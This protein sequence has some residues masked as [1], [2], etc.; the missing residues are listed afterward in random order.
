MSYELK[1]KRAKERLARHEALAQERLVRQAYSAVPELDAN[2][3]HQVL[4][5]HSRR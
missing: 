3:G 2:T 4:R 1:M 5:F